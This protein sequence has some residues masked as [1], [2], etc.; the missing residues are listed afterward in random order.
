MWLILLLILAGCVK[1]SQVDTPIQ[2]NQPK[3]IILTASTKFLVNAKEEM[4]YG[5]YADRYL[6]NQIGQNI[7]STEPSIVI[8]FNGSNFIFTNDGQLLNWANSTSGAKDFAKM[9]DTIT[10]YQNYATIRGFLNNDALTE[11]YTDSLINA[12]SGPAP[13]LTGLYD[14]YNYT[15]TFY[16]LPV[17]S[18]RP[19]FGSFNDKASSLADYNI[20]PRLNML[21]S[22]TWFRGKKFFYFSWRTISDLRAVNFDNTARS[23]L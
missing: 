8:G 4:T 18:F 21:A 20:N 5:Q 16:W 19:T 22:R 6:N 7:Y 9:L 3:E 10:L 17:I 2:Q 15:S 12:T 23:K 13:F 14:G 1:K 11:A